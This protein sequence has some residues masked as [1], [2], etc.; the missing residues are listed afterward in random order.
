[1]YSQEGTG[2][3]GRPLVYGEVLFDRFAEEGA[4]LGGAPF[5]VAWH[6]Q[7][8]G[9][10]PLFI[11]RIGEDELGGTVLR[12]MRSWGMDTGGIQRD[13]RHPTGVVQVNLEEGEPRFEILPRQAYD[14]IQAPAALEY[15]DGEGLSLMYQGTLAARHPESRAALK[16]LTARLKLPIF[17]DVNLR[18]PWWDKNRVDGCLQAARWVKMNEDELALLTGLGTTTGAEDAEKAAAAFLKTKKL[19]M[20]VVTLGSR[21][22]FLLQGDRKFRQPAAPVSQV[23]DS[24]GAGDAFSAVCILGLT[25]G[26]DPGLTLGR[27]LEFASRIVEQRGATGRDPGLYENFLERWKI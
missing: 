16:D 9:L 18:P 27:S 21:G 24:V 13:S 25:L 26:W 8:F 17:M 20:L 5:N 14:F 6:L 12:E 10:K 7:G 15:V 23:V 3:T 22:A 1:M 2:V 19:A 11:S 4:V